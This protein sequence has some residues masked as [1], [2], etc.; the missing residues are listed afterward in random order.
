MGCSQAEF[1][2]NMVMSVLTRREKVLRVVI[3]KSRACTLESFCVS[4]RSA[5]P[6][7]FCRKLG[8]DRTSSYN[9]MAARCGALWPMSGPTVIECQRM[10]DTFA[11]QEYSGV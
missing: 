9:T 4:V 3:V 1:C 8:A 2:L 11:L 6:R 5:E 10:L 7:V